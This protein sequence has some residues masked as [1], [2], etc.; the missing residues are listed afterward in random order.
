MEAIMKRYGNRPY[1]VRDHVLAE[2]LSRQMEILRES[3]RKLKGNRW[4]TLRRDFMFA[5]GFL[6]AGIGL[7]RLIG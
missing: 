5:A 2:I 7:G 1:S 4:E 6:A 3:Q